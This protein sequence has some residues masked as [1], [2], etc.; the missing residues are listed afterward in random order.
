MHDN[1][2]NRRE[3][4]AGAAGAAALR[5]VRV[6]GANDRLRL[7]VIG[8]GDRGLLGEALQFTKD[9]NAEIAAVC[10]TWRVQRDK[11][12]GAVRE[13]GG[14]APEQYVHFQD[15]LARKDIDA[16]IISTPDHA[17]C[18]MLSAAVRAGKD[19][20][21][22]KPLAMNMRELIEAVDAV[23][24][25]GRVVQVGT[26]VRSWAPSV[27]ARAFVASGGL[28]RVYKIEQSRNSYRPYWHRYG[29]RPVHETDVD[30]KAFLLHRKPRPW[31]PDQYTAW[32][33]YRDFSLGPHSG[34]M[35]HFIDLVHYITGAKAPKRVT[36]LGGIY[37]WKDKRNVPDSIE[38]LLE[39]PD[40]GF[41]VRY[42]TTFG[43]DQNSY[44]KFFGTR[45]VMDATRWDRPW[46][47]R[48][49]RGAPDR[50]AEDARIPEAETTH[51]MK[52]FFECVRSRKAP[53]APIEAGYAH[54]V[55]AIMADESYVRGARM[56]YDPT[57]RAIKAG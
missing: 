17:H 5:P 28:G 11:A 44:I 25:S 26:Q 22:E 14:A 48:A 34:L 32:Y 18:T 6:L 30:W 12:V 39:Y 2:L 53:A 36:A 3:F 10:D 7:A 47:L 51:H 27:A 19:A 52:N 20:Y 54:A 35:V 45:G 43:T 37:R 23:K 46:V 24:K 50:L 42:N 21:I 15:V 40:D 56:M 57:K 55:A 38:V 31:D 16:V 4:I 13:A 33:G 41:L 8:C 49:E 9:V 1:D 29:E